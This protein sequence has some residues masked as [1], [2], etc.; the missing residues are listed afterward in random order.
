MTSARCREL[1]V[2]DDPVALPAVLREL[3]RAGRPV[4]LVPT[5]GALHA[6]HRALIRAARAVPDAAAVVSIFVNPP[7]FTSQDDLDRY[8]RPR[9]A[10]L[11][12]C[13]QEGVDVVFAPNVEAMYPRGSGTAVHPGALGSEL[14]G[15]SRPGHFTGVLTVVAM[16][17]G[18]VG[19]DQAFF[20][21]KDYQ[22]LVLIQ[23]M[24]ADLRMGVQVIGVPTVREGDGLALSSR[25]VHLDPAA[26]AAAVVLPVALRA[27]A[28]AGEWG[29]DA[30]FAAAREVVCGQPGVELDY[31][32]LRGPQL[33]PVPR[34]GP[35]RLLV[36][37]TVGATRLIDNIGLQLNV[38]E[39]H[40][41]SD[42][43]GDP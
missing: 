11:S 5:M 32:E 29:A 41:D 42:G 15:A 1:T 3:R 8:P 25:N 36:A 12:V 43:R 14:E 31:L 35:A 38:A 20:G 17:F 39:V 2:C 7:Q 9:D 4:M 16:L 10:D 27:G 26:R 22:Q 33:G 21:E 13:R 23:R 18:I 6:G 19:P 24:V 28:Q 37:A 34:R 40:A 30:V